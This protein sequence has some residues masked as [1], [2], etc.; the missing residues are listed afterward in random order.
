M[1]KSEDQFLGC[2]YFLGESKPW[3]INDETL[4]ISPQFARFGHEGNTVVSESEY[5]FWDKYIGKNVT[6]NVPNYIWNLVDSVVAVGPLTNVANALRNGARIKN[7]I[8]M[9]GSL[10]DGI[11]GTQFK[12]S[13]SKDYNFRFFHFH[14][15]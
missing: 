11:Y 12:A 4:D 15:F 3:S 14:K 5:T 1:S 2:V 6:E 7:L 9:G 13:L 10:V 8:L